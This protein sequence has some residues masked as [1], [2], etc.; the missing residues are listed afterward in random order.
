MLTGY[1]RRCSL[2]V[3]IDSDSLLSDHTAPFH[4]PTWLLLTLILGLSLLVRQRWLDIVPS[5]LDRGIVRSLLLGACSG[6]HGAAP[7]QDWA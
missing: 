6:L 4:G 1:S 2:R 5:D 7:Y 3:L